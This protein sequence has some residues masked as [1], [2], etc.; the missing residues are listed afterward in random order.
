MGNM[1]P[2]AAFLPTVQRY[3][4]L[5]KP[6]VLLGNVLTGAAGFGLASAWLRSFDAVLFIA[7]IGG[8]T[9]IIA[10]ACA[11][12]NVLDRDIDRLMERTKQRVVASG[13]VAP[14]RA[15]AFAVLLGT[16]GVSVLG[17]WTNWLVVGI[18][19][20]GYIVYVWLYGAFSKRRSLHG[21][22]VGSISGAAPIL[23]GYVAV[24]GRIDAG[25]ILVFLALFFWQFPEFY[26]IAVYRRAEY[27]AA[28]V[29]VITVVRSIGVAKRWIFIN[30]ALCLL[31]A[32]LLTSFHYTGYVYLF[33]MAAVG[34][35]W[36]LVAVRGFRSDDKAYSDRWARRMFHASLNVLLA[37]SLLIV[38]GPLLP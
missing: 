2:N 5:T 26:S 29:P 14:R 23:A 32:L 15:M 28:R 1:P 11:L 3:V 20:G 18:G 8:M 10:S 21:T 13:A 22:L 4:S 31:A 19:I 25:A 33:A 37:Y 36:L 9:L 17:V 6:G 16:F 30:A 34:V 35:Y 7:A 24:R 12:N 38:L 27:Q